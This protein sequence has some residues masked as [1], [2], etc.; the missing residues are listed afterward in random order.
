MRRVV[1]SPPMGRPALILFFLSILAGC[2]RAVPPIGGPEAS[3]TAIGVAVSGGVDGPVGRAVVL[4]AVSGS[5]VVARPSGAPRP[6]A[7]TS[8]EADGLAWR[9]TLA[10]GV[11]GTRILSAWASRLR[12]RGWSDA[13]LLR[14]VV[15][16]E[17]YRRLASDDLAGLRIEGGRLVVETVRPLTDLPTRLAHPALAPPPEFG[18]GAFRRTAAAERFV[19][20][21]TRGVAGFSIVAP[22]SADVAVVYGEDVAAVGSLATERLPEWDLRYVLV[23][24]PRARWTNDP[25]FRR[26]IA[27]SIDADDAVRF[28]FDGRGSTLRG[29]VVDPET[30]PLASAGAPGMRPTTSVPRLRIVHDLADDAA[31]AIASRIEAEIESAGAI[32]DREPVPAEE[33]A[34]RVDAGVA[35]AVLIH[36]PATGDPV[37]DLRT[38][39]ERAGGTFADACRLLD[40]AT[41][42]VSRD[43]RTAVAEEVERDLLA[44][45]TLVPLVRLDAWLGVR[46]GIAGLEPG[47]AGDLALETVTWR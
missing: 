8:W 20:V 33:I 30:A 42:R 45:A 19:A 27:S 38:T 29:L 21:S 13:W 10:P 24:N 35:L 28:L 11:D 31:R 6:G 3:P 17:A 40:A 22:A 4:R 15:G 41:A 46:D 2:P 47:L 12:D 26:W 5:L 43:G 37:L 23:A 7:S 9:F 1:A 25:T 36:L 39:L 14:P 16:A 44:Q 18:A 34:A 32:V